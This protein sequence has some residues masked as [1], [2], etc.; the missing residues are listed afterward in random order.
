MKQGK[1]VQTYL[2]GFVDIAYNIESLLELHEEI[3]VPPKGCAKGYLDET[4]LGLNKMKNVIEQINSA[5]I[6]IDAVFK[7]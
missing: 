6:E 3:E 1:L 4:K 7:D 2:E 5:L